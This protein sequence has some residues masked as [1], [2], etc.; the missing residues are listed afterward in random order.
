MSAWDK[1]FLFISARW[2]IENM[3]L[4]SLQRFESP[5]SDPFSDL[6]PVFFWRIKQRGGPIWL[7]DGIPVISAD[8]RPYAIRNRVPLCRCGRSSN[9]PICD[10]ALAS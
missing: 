6:P 7:R 4:L 5:F 9:K 3:I 8:G 10:G 2:A 1:D